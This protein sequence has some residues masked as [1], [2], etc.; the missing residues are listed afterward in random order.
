MMPRKIIG[1]ITLPLS[2][3]GCGGTTALLL[4][5]APS[6]IKEADEVNKIKL[7]VSPSTA[8][9]SASVRLTVDGYSRIGNEVSIK[10]D[11]KTWTVSGDI[12]LLRSE[13]PEGQRLLS[14]RQL[15]TAS[16]DIDLHVRDR[17]TIRG[18]GTVTFTVRVGSRTATAS[19]QILLNASGL[20]SLYVQPPMVGLAPGTKQQF[21]A[22][23]RN[24]QG[25]A[26]PVTDVVWEAA[27]EV[28]IDSKGLVTVPPTASQGT[29]EI[30]AKIVWEGKESRDT[31]Q[32]VI[33]PGE[34]ENQVYEILVYPRDVLLYTGSSLTFLAIAID[35]T[36]VAV[37]SAKFKW[38]TSST[39]ASIDPSSGEFRASTATGNVQVIAALSNAK[40]NLAGLAEVTVEA[41]P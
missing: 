18:P 14:D 31:A 7:R 28:S 37:P 40:E 6:L 9:P 15:N 3:V 29:A 13:T 27:G 24:A 30:A 32:I 23:A 4:A 26:V 20:L 8:E 1:F 25:V 39:I 5:L 33:S 21:I 35:R 10:N 41:K 22:V 12:D 17:D 11:L 2:I 34:P 16:N 38:N 36:G 19:L